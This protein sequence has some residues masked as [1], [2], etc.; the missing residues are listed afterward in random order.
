MEIRC[1]IS[2]TPSKADVPPTKPNPGTAVVRPSNEGDAK[3]MV[4]AMLPPPK[5]ARDFLLGRGYAAGMPNNKRLEPNWHL[6]AVVLCLAVIGLGLG[7]IFK[8]WRDRVTPQ[9]MSPAF[10]ASRSAKARA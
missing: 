6:L 3:G 2:D 10:L 9:S 4:P 7:L 1:F 5:G 8:W